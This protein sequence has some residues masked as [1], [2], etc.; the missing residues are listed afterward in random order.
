MN[1]SEIHAA[2]GWFMIP[3][4]FIAIINAALIAYI[5]YLF[6]SKSNTLDT[7]LEF[8][9]Q[10]GLLALAW[11]V[12]GTIVGLFAAFN[13]LEQ[14]KEPLPFNIISGGLKVSLLTVL[15]GFIVYIISMA[16]YLIVKLAG[17]VRAQTTN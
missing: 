9:K 13:A 5:I 17:K 11:G 1:L 4:D 15:Y 14:L 2:G 10:F 16:V 3:I 7:T 6:I 12:F 8:L